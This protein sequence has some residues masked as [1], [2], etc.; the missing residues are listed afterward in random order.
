M[1][2]HVHM[3]P[4]QGNS[5]SRRRAVWSGAYSRGTRTEGG[6]VSKLV[7]E[8][9]GASPRRFKP[10]PA[11]KDS[12]VE[13]LGEIPAH[14]EVRRLKTIASVQLSNVDKKSVEGQESV[15]LCN[16]VDVY[17]NGR[18]TA[19][20]E[21]MAATASPVQVQRFSLQKGD[22]LI[23]KDSESWTD[24]AVPAVIAEDLPDVL[25]GYHLALVRPLAV[26]CDGGFL[27]HAFSAIG[28]RDQ[29]QIVANGITRFGLGGDA[30][31]SGLFAMPPIDE[32]RRIAAHLDREAA[33]IDALVAKKERLIELLQE[34][35]TALITQAVT[36]GLDPN[37]PMKD[38][39]VEWLGEIP[40]HWVCLALSRVTTSRCDGPFGSHLKS[41]HYSESGVRVIRLQNI[42]WATFQDDDHAFLD[43]QYASQL[44][45][46]GVRPGDLLVAGLGDAGHPVGR[47]CFAPSSLG[48]AMVKADCFRFRLEQNLLTPAFAAYQLTAA[49]D[50]AA[51]SDSTGATRSR[52]NL[53][54]SARRKVA[55]PPPQ[56]QLSILA[57]I[58]RETARIDALLAK[59]REA[60]DRLKELRTALISA[61]VTGKID[62]RGGVE[63]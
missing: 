45:D 55:I 33:R 50:A 1:L 56:E 53:M 48:P 58:E 21:F 39:G 18:I 36:K 37:V 11:Y 38:S 30:I 3:V 52:M 25:C 41:E 14:W 28:P 46:H 13:W 15:R 59:V 44:G 6:I 54:A 5:R 24:I 57:L 7:K 35:R 23:T 34:R 10:Y 20:V 60:I 47:A 17:Y 16:Y 63:E 4:A 51:G 29:F 62:V 32:Q 12:G 2:P 40:T 19:D 43:E 26:E 9:G 27:A 61:A 31:R 22:V 8:Q 49:A 42:G